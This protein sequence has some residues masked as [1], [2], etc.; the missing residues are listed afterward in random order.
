MNG[1]IIGNLRRSNSKPSEGGL[2]DAPYRAYGCVGG[3][4]GFATDQRST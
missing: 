2:A 1:A 3:A 4:S